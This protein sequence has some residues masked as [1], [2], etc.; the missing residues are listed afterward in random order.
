[1]KYGVEKTLLLPMHRC[2]G[3]PTGPFWNG[4][5]I[6]RVVAEHLK[7]DISE[8]CLD[9]SPSWAS[10]MYSYSNMSSLITR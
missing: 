10:H 7:C 2:D 4:K 3:W 1:M 9:R 8:E 6:R 5:A